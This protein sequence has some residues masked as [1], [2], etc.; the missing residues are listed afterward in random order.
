MQK[1]EIDEILRWLKTTDLVEVTFKEN[2]KGFTLGSAGGGTTTVPYPG[3]HLKAVCSK[4]IGIF[5]FN[6]P[7]KPRL[8]EEGSAV[9]AGSLLGIIESLGENVPVTSPGPGRL[10]KVCVEDGDPVQYGQPLFF[11]EE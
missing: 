11:I 9:T 6:E 10:H 4:S 7:G 1:E 5:H 8:S 2:G 3:R